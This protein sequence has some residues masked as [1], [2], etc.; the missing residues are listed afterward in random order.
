MKVF[1]ALLI[2]SMVLCVTNGEESEERDKRQIFDSLGGMALGKRNPATWRAMM[3]N[4]DPRMGY[5][6]RIVD[7]LGGNYLVKRE[8][9]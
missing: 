6:K 3:M 4:S 8:E 9:K 5:G 7:S 1:F 2:V